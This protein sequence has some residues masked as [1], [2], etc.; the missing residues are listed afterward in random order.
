MKLLT[1]LLASTAILLIGLT[2][3]LTCNFGLGN[4]VRDEYVLQTIRVTKRATDGPENLQL[5]LDY[6]AS[7]LL[8]QQITFVEVQ[9]SSTSS[10][11]FTY[12]AD[13]N[14]KHVQTTVTS[15]TPIEEFVIT[16]TVYGFNWV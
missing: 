4:R 13:N 3:V 15:S 7:P 6:K 8:N 1:P 11:S 9:T 16:M 5:H 10:C 12:P 2:P 14:S